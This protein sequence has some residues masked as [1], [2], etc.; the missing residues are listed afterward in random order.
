MLASRIAFLAVGVGLGLALGLAFRDEPAS[1]RSQPPRV[2]HEVVTVR[3]PAPPPVEA[4]EAEVRTEVVASQPL[5]D[6]TTPALPIPEEEALDP[7]LGRLIVDFSRAD[8]SEPCVHVEGRELDGDRI[9]RKVEADKHGL[10]ETELLAGTHTIAWVEGKDSLGQ[11]VLN[12]EIREGWVTRIEVTDP[13]LPHLDPIRAGLGR[14][15]VSVADLGG[16]PLRNAMVRLWGREFDGGDETVSRTT[17][18]SG[19]VRFDVLPGRY[20]VKVGLR[21][22][23]AVVRAGERTMLDVHYRQEGEIL[24]DGSLPGAVGITALGPGRNARLNARMWGSA[25]KSWRFIY[26]PPGEYLVT[27]QNR[28]RVAGQVTVRSRQATRFTHVPPSGGLRLNAIL[29]ESRKRQHIQIRV[30]HAD[31]GYRVGNTSSFIRD[32]LSWS[33]ANL[34]P[35]TYRITITGRTFEIYEQ[36]VSI[37]AS[38]V[39]WRVELVPKN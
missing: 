27:Y 14:L 12:V 10:A 31:T 20:L 37:G 33:L 22:D 2:V 3:E 4:P 15:E 38:V 13:D 30:V 23:P 5:P 1:G 36:E 21:S 9:S 17:N 34:A 18:E 6:P 29:P 28:N 26:L 25:V 35:G 11:R 8:W 24:I 19:R 39:D 7:G 16:G 32:G